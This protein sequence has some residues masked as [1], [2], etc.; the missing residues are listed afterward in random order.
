MKDHNIFGS[1]QN[2]IVNNMNDSI[3]C[4]DISFDNIDGGSWSHNFHSSASGFDKTNSFSTQGGHVT[5][6]NVF[7]Q[8][9]CT[10]K[11]IQS[12]LCK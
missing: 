5:S 6:S 9:S 10:C 11:Q 8:N 7:S 4:Q 12:K 2:D 1:L 3:A